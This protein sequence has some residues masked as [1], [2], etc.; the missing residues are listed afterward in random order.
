MIAWIYNEI[1]FLIRNG[2]YL[3]F[4]NVKGH[5]D[6]QDNNV[7]DKLAVRA[8]MESNHGGE[9]ICKRPKLPCRPVF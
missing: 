2:W 8:S 7:V 1:K 9:D 6:I 4:F 5:V 3:K